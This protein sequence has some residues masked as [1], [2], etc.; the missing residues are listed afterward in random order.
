MALNRSLS[1]NGVNAF[2]LGWKDVKY[3]VITSRAPF[4]EHLLNWL[5]TWATKAVGGTWLLNSDLGT[6]E[7]NASVG[8]ISNGIYFSSLQYED[9][10]GKFGHV[11][12]YG[13]DSNYDPY[14]EVWTLGEAYRTVLFLEPPTGDLLEWLNFCGVKQT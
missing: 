10:G 11:L 13:G 2:Q 9:R 5:A 4:P 7:V 8:F 1:Y 6:T 14:T 3:R 12:T